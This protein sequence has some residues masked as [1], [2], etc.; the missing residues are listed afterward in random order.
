MQLEVRSN[1]RV[2]NLVST[3]LQTCLYLL[4]VGRRPGNSLFE[5]VIS[6]NIGR[7]W[8]LLLWPQIRASYDQSICSVLARIS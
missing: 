6:E 3:W 4:L 2:T 5:T 8:I 1:D 7:Y